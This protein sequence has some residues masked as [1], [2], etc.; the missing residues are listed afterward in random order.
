MGFQH[1]LSGLNAAARNLDI[2]GHNVAN[3]NTIGAKVT[4]AEF[5]D[6]YAN[7]VGGGGTF[8]GLGVTINDVTQTFS[9]GDL[10]SS[11][12]PLDLAI[13][14]TGFFRVSSDEEGVSYTRNGQFKLDSDGYVVNSDGGRL[15][16]YPADSEGQIQVGVA[17]DLV[18]IASNL[19]PEMSTRMDAEIN[20]DARQDEP[21]DPFS[22]SSPLT[23]NA[24]TS[25]NLFDAQGRDT[26]VA[27][28]FVKTANNTWDVHATTDGVA[29]GAGPLT[30]LT[31]S[32]DGTVDIAA[33][34]MPV[35][36]TVPTGSGGSI[37]LDMHLG[38]ITQYGSVFGVNSLKQDGYSTGQLAGYAI[39]ESGMIMARYTNG[40]ARAQGQ[41][42][43]VNFA[44]PQ[45]L[46]ANGGNSW[47]ETAKSGQPLLGVPGSAS[48]G[49][50][51]SG[52]LEQSNV[53]L[54][55]ELVNMIMAQRSYQANAQTIRA[56]DQIVQTIIN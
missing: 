27:M 37:A 49:G 45:G 8:T 38:N 53:D 13:N 28:Y 55:G 1:G 48:L 52:A 44:N 31:F 40:Q 34:P 2:I 9:Q 35:P 7:A 18:V 10:T 47:I 6:R 46:A 43:L 36:I 29:I 12:N 20:L 16:G 26:T 15:S 5:A 33:S 32:S 25:L 23:Y 50:V 4:R 22:P 54:T 42:A 17:T 21:V 3:A 19:S 14:G 51:Q 24:A 11:N 30:S 56:Q 39:D 41:I